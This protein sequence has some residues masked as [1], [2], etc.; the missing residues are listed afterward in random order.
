M[1]DNWDVWSRVCALPEDLVLHNPYMS[2]LYEPVGGVAVVLPM[3]SV[4]DV[5]DIMDSG[6]GHP[7]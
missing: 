6:R 7:C 2:V 5:P 1:K 4:Q 3:Y